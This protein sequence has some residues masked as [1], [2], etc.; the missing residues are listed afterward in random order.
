MEETPAYFRYWGKADRKD[1]SQYHLLPYHCLDVAAAA[2]VWLDR[3]LVLRTRFLQQSEYNDK[4]TTAWILFFIALHDYGKFDIRFQR[5]ADH[6]RQCLYPHRLEHDLPGLNFSRKYDHGA[7]GLYWFLKDHSDRFHFGDDIQMDLSDPFGENTSP[8][9]DW[10]AWRPWIEMVCGHH[11]YIRQD[12]HVKNWRLP[13][14]AKALAPFERETRRAWVSH[15]EKFFLN[16]NGLNL[17][18]NPP[19]PSPLL[20]GFCSVSD[21]LGSRSDEEAFRSEKAI[22]PLDQYFNEKLKDA[23]YVLELSGILGEKKP[24]QGIENLL[25]EGTSAHGLQQIVDD[26]PLESGL[27]IVEAPTGSGKTEMALAYAWRLIDKGL[28]E[29][30]VFALP[31]Q[32]TSNKMFDRLTTLALELFKANPNL[33]LAHGNARF[34]KKFITLKNTAQPHQGQDEAWVQCCEWLGQSRKRLFLGQIGV[35][36]VDQVLIAVLP[37]RHRFV[38]GFGLGRSIM[39]VDEVHAYDAYMYG[40][41]QQVLVE[42]K[43]AGGS[44]ILLSA[45]LPF[46]QRQTLL[47]AWT[48]KT[49]SNKAL[50]AYPL[51]TWRGETCSRKFQPPDNSNGRI[52]GRKVQMETRPVSD[53]RPDQTLI[54][55]MIDAAQKGAQ[56]ALI[57]NLVDDAQYFYEQTQQLTNSP[58]LLYHSRF[59]LKDRMEK[60]DS[61]D[62]CF[63]KHG[64]R[65][66]GRILI[67]TQVLEQSLDYDVDLMVTQLCPVDLLFQRM[68]RLH[69]H[70]RPKRPNGFDQ[71]RCIVL[72]TDSEGYGLHDHIYQNSLVMWRTAQG[73]IRQADTMIEFPEAYRAWIE[74]IYDDNLRGDEPSW[75][76][77][78]YKAWQRKIEN[79][80]MA[81]RQM[82]KWSR[83]TWLIDTDQKI[84]AVT[85]DE[86]MS[87]P[88]VP[89]VRTPEGRKLLDGC[90]IE[91]LEENLKSE[92]I[93][94]N[95]VNV[96]CYWDRWINTRIID[97]ITWFPMQEYKDA[98]IAETSKDKL[99]YTKSMGLKRE[100]VASK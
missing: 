82:I 63:G 76:L 89:L 95:S 11:G 35:C 69:R 14:T 7:A 86:E 6:V 9:K 24:Y 62:C 27:T 87:L 22:L 1:P 60:E 51:I 98:W 12:A 72:I 80:E 52:S 23:A 65:S 70:A 75:V 29:S 19:P 50:T 25:P 48:P 31:T 93:A 34:N 33:L 5:K 46:S 45:T 57:C 100:R 96:P 13:L 77:D 8:N 10:D 49:E 3:S 15:L 84:Q 20:A 4:K 68:G 78:A 40:L 83:D 90:I 92:A 41:M 30:I 26:L 28:A 61:V 18:D 99:I 53:M 32:A 21:W 17:Y 91:K 56:V 43:Q 39:I 37:V 2:S 58:V 67:G 55:E 71:P 97:E 42:Q 79:K 59:T 54:K 38:R 85:R 47:N 64:D 44:T 88:L 74:D 66:I 16:P 94:M 73:L 81:A 36:T